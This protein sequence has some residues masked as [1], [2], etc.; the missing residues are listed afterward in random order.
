MV[1]VHHAQQKDQQRDMA[2]MTEAL[3]GMV[4]GSRREEEEEDDG[5]VC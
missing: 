2:M 5:R 4:T 3:I 1:R